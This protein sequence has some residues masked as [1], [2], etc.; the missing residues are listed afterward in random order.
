LAALDAAGTDG[1]ALADLHG[2][3]AA[4]VN[5]ADSAYLSATRYDAFGQTAATYD[6]GGSFPTPWG[7]QSR[8]DVSPDAANPLYDVS[9][10]YYSPA[11]G[12]QSIL[13]ELMELFR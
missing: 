10:R 2:N 11:S 7:F 12:A 6:S 4:L 13:N 1:F 3:A 9:A 5:A 8:L